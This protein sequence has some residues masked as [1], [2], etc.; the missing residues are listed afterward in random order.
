MAP[1]ALC[2]G[3]FGD[4]PRWDNVVLSTAYPSNFSYPRPFRYRDDRIDPRL[5]PELAER[6]SR[7]QVLKT[8]AVLVMRFLDAELRDRVLPVREVDVVHFD[9]AADNHSLYFRLGRFVDFRKFQGL[10]SAFL[11]IPGA[12]LGRISN[13][14]ILFRAGLNLDLL[15]WA[16][17]EAEPDVWTYLTDMWASDSSPINEMARHALFIRLISFSRWRWSKTPRRVDR[18]HQE[19]DRYG[20]NLAEGTAREFVFAHRV[21]ALIGSA[22]TFESVSLSL[23]NIRTI[24]ASR[25]EEPI[26]HNY[27]THATK[28][29]G[30]RT[31]G[32]WEEVQLHPSAEDVGTSAGWRLRTVPIPVPLRVRFNPLYRARTTWLLT[33]LLVVALFADNVVDRFL[34]AQ[35]EGEVFDWTEPSLLLLLA[36]SAVLAL[37]ISALRSRGSK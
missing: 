28:L 12:D 4:G 8:R 24:D 27:Q 16:P 22:Q 37:I 34:K 7:R 25:V 3:F 23:Q 14:V 6:K 36:S 17:V 2:V 13:E 18:S 30:R 1:E 20:W 35:E 10:D 15:P 31:S 5:L 21:P 33:L 26:N 32:A 9:F 11:D 29:S 19:G